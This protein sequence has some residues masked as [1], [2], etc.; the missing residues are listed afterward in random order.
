[1]SFPFLPFVLPFAVPRPGGSIRASR[2]RK[3]ARA[4]GTEGSSRT[5]WSRW[6]MAIPVAPALPSR[7]GITASSIGQYTSLTRPSRETFVVAQ[8]PDRRPNRALDRR[9]AAGFLGVHANAYEQLRD[10]RVGVPH[11]AGVQLVSA[12]H[13]AWDGRHQIELT[14]SSPSGDSSCVDELA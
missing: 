1:M 9:M 5:A 3:A 13:G 12:P 14:R 11:V 2:E 4:S 10:Q 8:R 7:T 6:R